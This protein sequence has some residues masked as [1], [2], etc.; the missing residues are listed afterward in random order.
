MSTASFFRAMNVILCI[1]GF[2]VFFC[3]QPVILGVQA[4][5]WYHNDLNVK[6]LG[7]YGF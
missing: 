7:R 6:A 5:A 2:N 4:R 1:L 3:Y